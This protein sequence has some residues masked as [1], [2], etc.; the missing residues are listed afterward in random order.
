MARADQFSVPAAT[1]ALLA[2]VSPQA[3]SNL[4]RRRRLHSRK[5]RNG[6][7]LLVLAE[8][9]AYA[10]RPRHSRLTRLRQSLSP[11]EPTLTVAERPLHAHGAASHSTGETSQ[12]NQKS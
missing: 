3:I 7:R 12:E 11:A 10:Q 5:H 2:G 9:L 8:V 4:C 1:A 6:Q